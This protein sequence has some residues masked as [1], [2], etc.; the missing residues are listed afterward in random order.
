MAVPEGLNYVFDN[1]CVESALS[2]AL[3]ALA[4]KGT[5]ALAGVPKPESSTFSLDLFGMVLGG[6]RVV[7]ISEGESAPQE[8]IPAM[9]DLFM[10]GRFPFD[11]LLSFYSLDQINEAVKAHYDGAAVKV[12]LT[13]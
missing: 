8:F 9:I 1:T 11:K 6:L 4:P 13:P 5:L 12:V 2:A 3:G 10:E 7:G